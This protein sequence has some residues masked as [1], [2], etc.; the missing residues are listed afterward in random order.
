VGLSFGGLLG[1]RDGDQPFQGQGEH[2]VSGGR[3]GAM[4]EFS[5]DMAVL[6]GTRSSVSRLSG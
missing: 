6:R 4:M 1:T 2:R 3:N 5:V